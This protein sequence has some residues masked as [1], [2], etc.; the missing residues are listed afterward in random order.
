MFALIFTV[1]PC[2]TT[3]TAIAILPT[4]GWLKKWGRSA[5]LYQGFNPQNRI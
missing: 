1:I 3:A 2:S 4:F 5:A